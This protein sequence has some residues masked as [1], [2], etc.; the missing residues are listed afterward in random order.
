MFKN[1]LKRF[2]L[3]ALFAGLLSSTF[4]YAETDGKKVA[5]IVGPSQDAFIG[6]WV[7]TFIENAS[8]KGIE[9]ESFSSPFDP[10]LQTRQI[11]DAV[12]QKFD[13]IL[14]QPISQNAILP[15]LFRAKE[16]SIPVITIMVKLDEKAK[17]L[18]VS[19]VGEDAYTL[20][21]LAG[22]A[23]VNALKNA[24]KET[25]RIA[26]I[27]GSLSEGI[28]PVRMAGFKDTI[29]KLAPGVEIVAVEDV[30]WNPVAGEQ[31]AGQ[32]L[33]RFSSDGGLDGIYGMNDRLANSVIQAATTIGVSTG[34]GKDDLIVIGGNCQGPGMRNMQTNA[35]AATVEM[36]PAVSAK[37]AVGVLDK[38]FSDQAVEKTYFETHTIITSANL[39]SHIEACSY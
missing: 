35:M 9:V 18:Y 30:K 31:V 3:G 19:Y 16:S 12:A 13:A 6:T 36:L 28:A 20:G 24:G 33:V 15:V 27:T 7:K 38:L 5:L 14:V 39:A 21:S 11:D 37:V 22:E 10:A 29:A 26:A 4:A 2:A 8:A 32:L 23:M 17:D 34:T 25:A 1:S